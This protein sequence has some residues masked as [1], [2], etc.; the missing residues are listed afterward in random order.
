MSRHR[1]TSTLALVGRCLVVYLIAATAFYWF[2]EPI[3]NKSYAVPAEP[4]KPAATEQQQAGKADH[5]RLALGL[6]AS[7]ALPEESMAVPDMPERSV[8]GKPAKKVSRQQDA[9]SA[10]HLAHEPHQQT[11]PAGFGWRSGNGIW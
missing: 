4:A 10:A 1:Q 11:A 5:L 7:I 3:R 6:R 2:I 8:I 9:S